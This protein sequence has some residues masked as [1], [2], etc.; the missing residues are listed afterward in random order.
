MTYHWINPTFRFQ[1]E[2]QTARDE[3]FHIVLLT[4]NH[5]SLKSL[6]GLKKSEWN[7]IAGTSFIYQI[8]PHMGHT[9]MYS[10]DLKQYCCRSVNKKQTMMSN[11]QLSHPFLNTETTVT[12]TWVWETYFEI[13]GNSNS[14][15]HRLSCRKNSVFSLLHFHKKACN[16]NITKL[17]NHEHHS[18][19]IDHLTYSAMCQRCFG[20]QKHLYR[21]TNIP[22]NI[23]IL[24]I[25]VALDKAKLIKSR[26]T[27]THTSLHN[28]L[29]T[30]AAHRRICQNFD[31]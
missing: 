1:S 28:C 12:F 9:S 22:L 10:E 8:S 11:M 5:L 6:L 19:T 31:L 7:Q 21:W 20:Q 16:L 25:E 17:R 18:I 2:I 30:H 4:I 26:R 3:K 24:F 15:S 29:V 14:Q 13:K 23:V 27:I